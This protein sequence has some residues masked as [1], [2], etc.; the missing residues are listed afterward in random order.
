MKTGLAVLLLFSRS[1]TSD[2]DPM[3]YSTPGLPVLHH[4]PE[5]AQTRVH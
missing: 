5:F 1:V 4:L 3:D 2:C